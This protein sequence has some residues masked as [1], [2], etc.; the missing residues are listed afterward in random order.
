MKISNP[1]QSPFTKGELKY[2]I[3]KRSENFTK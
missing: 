2:G 1:P 3:G